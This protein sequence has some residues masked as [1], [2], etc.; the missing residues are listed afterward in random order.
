MWVFYISF[1]ET[2]SDDDSVVFPRDTIKDGNVMVHTS[3]EVKARRRTFE[4]V[5]NTSAHI[6]S[7]FYQTFIFLS[8]IFFKITLFVENSSFMYLWNICVKKW[9]IF[10][11]LQIIICNTTSRIWLYQWIYLLLPG[12]GD[13]F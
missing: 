13:N 9:M 7:N 6:S 4:N 12:G 10:R 2:T 8:L 5:E 1:V 3:T 11:R